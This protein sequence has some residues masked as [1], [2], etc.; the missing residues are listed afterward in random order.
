MTTGVLGT[1]HVFPAASPFDTQTMMFPMVLPLP[2]DSISLGWG[3]VCF[4]AHT[5]S[6]SMARGL[7]VG[8]FPSKVTVP[9]LVAAAKAT[10]GHA[11]TVTSPA[12]SHNL[13]PVARTI[14]SVL[15]GHL[16]L[17]SSGTVP[18]PYAIGECPQYLPPILP[19][20]HR[21]LDGAVGAG[22]RFRANSTLYAFS[23]ARDSASRGSRSGTSAC[24]RMSQPAAATKH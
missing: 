17:L 21:N 11:N 14:G 3:V 23:N 10:P 4:L 19:N 16:P 9:V 8:A 6:A 2:R 13:F 20:F 24:R 1:G 12:A 5:G 18:N 7:R 22:V 15:I